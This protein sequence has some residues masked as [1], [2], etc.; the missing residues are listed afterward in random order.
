MHTLIPPRSL[1]RRAMKYPSSNTAWG[2]GILEGHLAIHQIPV[3]PHLEALFQV[4][5]TEHNRSYR[6][7]SFAEF[8]KRI[9]E[10]QRHQ[11]EDKS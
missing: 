7:S 3:K 11:Q 6:Q 10:R 9:Q 2:F 5:L 4:Y 8:D 1:I